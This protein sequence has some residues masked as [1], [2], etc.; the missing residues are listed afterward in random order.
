MKKFKKQFL[1]SGKSFRL[2]LVHKNGEWKWIFWF[3]S[4][5]FMNENEFDDSITNIWM[6]LEIKDLNDYLFLL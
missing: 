3:H 4:Y 1:K 6:N 2:C 5:F